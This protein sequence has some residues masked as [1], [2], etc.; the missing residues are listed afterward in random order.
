MICFVTRHSS[1]AS[2]HSL[3]QNSFTSPTT[4]FLLHIFKLL[5]VFSVQPVI[6]IVESTAH[7]ISQTGR[8]EIHG[9]FVVGIIVVVVG[10]VV[11]VSSV[12]GIVVVVGIIVVVVV[13]G[14]GLLSLSPLG[15]MVVSG[16]IVVVS[17]VIV[18][19]GLLL[20]PLGIVVVSDAIVVVSVVIVVV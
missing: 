7:I 14:G 20:S 9:G 17:V 8:E 16:A 1:G 2:T 19:I 3:R 15:I 12:V 5:F 6:H 13:S 18:G 4:Q 11:V 10:I